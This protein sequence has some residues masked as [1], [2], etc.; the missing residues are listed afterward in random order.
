MSA[1]VGAPVDRVDGRLKVTGAAKYSAEIAVPNLAYGVMVLS[2]AASG[3][4][5][6]DATTALRAPG[7]IDVM[8]PQNAPRVQNGGQ[9]GGDRTLMVLQDEVVRYDRQP[10]AVVI[11]DTF[12]RA[13]DAAAMVRVR[14]ARTAAV[15]RFDAAPEYK[16]GTQGQGGQQ[17]QGG[18]QAQ[19]AQSHDV[20]KHKGDA[21]SALAAAAVKVDNV[22]VVPVEHHNPMEPHATVAAWDGDKLTV[23]EATQG[24]I[25]ARRKLATTFG[26]PASN[27]RVVSKFIGGGFGGK[28]SVWP[29]AVL[30]AMAAKLVNRPVK[31]VLSRPQ[32][33]GSVGF[34]PRTVQRVALGA[35]RDGKLT[36]LVHETSAQTSVFDEFMAQTGAL[37]AVLY[38]TPNLTITH[39]LRRLNYSTPTFMRAPGESCGS[40]ALESAMDELAYAT[41]IDP[42]ELRLRN[43]TNVDADGKPFSSRS[44]AQC[45]RAGA[46]RIGWSRRNPAARSM[47]EGNLLVGIGMAASTYPTHRSPA[48]AQVQVRADGS[49][50]VRSAGVDIGTGAYT[51]FSQVA[52][53]ALGVPVERVRMEL[54]DSDFPN[55]PNAGGS[56]LTASAGSAIKLAALDARAKLLALAGGDASALGA[57]GAIP[58]LLRAHGTDVVEGRADAKAG[59]EAHQYAMH[60]FGAQF[61][62]VRVDPDLGTVRVVRFVNAFGS[63]RILNEKTAKSQYMG[64]AIF[65]IGMALLE[66][67]RYDERTGRIMN[68]NL[69]DYLL[70]TNADVPAVESIIVPENDPHVNE[71]GVK[72][73]G[74]IGIV[75]AAAAVA[76]AVYHATGKRVRD[77][78]ITPEKLLA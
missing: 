22:Y 1:L 28:G 37:S 35:G 73:I 10:V 8:T 29:H 27:V 68:A 3:T 32:M 30:A 20:D 74:E 55:A 59:E 18:Q 48:S 19:A 66:H 7:V 67:T 76:N 23:Y 9:G 4:A 47:R 41:G 44:L 71:I 60:A 31:I 75:G 26:L 65:G 70:P 62:E 78:P 46:E 14:Y 13:V 6:V 52:A 72:G 54:G 40:F 25:N 64:G 16:P 39:R 17:P 24:I 5:S 45:I 2:T 36:A 77:L 61:A 53:D 15:T 43:D 51:V 58:A 12:E 49:V 57:A 21:A 33:F 69:A 11:A 38:A 34:R 56:T 42:L 63:G 50:V